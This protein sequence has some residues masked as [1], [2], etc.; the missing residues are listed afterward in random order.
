MS[1]QPETQIGLDNAAVPAVDQLPEYEPLTPDLVEDEAVRGDFVIRWSVVLLGLLFGWTQ[2]EDTSLLVRIRSGQLHPI[3][4]GSDVFSASATDRSWINLGWLSDVVLAGAYSVGGSRALTVLGALAA[5]LTFWWLSR[6]SVKGVSTW[7]GSICGMLALVAAFPQ[8]TPGPTG[9]TLLGTAAVVYQLFRWSEQNAGSF[10]WSIPITMFLWSQLDPRSWVG[11]VLIVLYTLS[12]VL[13]RGSEPNDPPN[14]TKNLWKIVGCS[15]LL[16]IV[17]PL[18]YHVVMSPWQA[19]ESEYPE[20]REYKVLDWPQAWQW[21]PVYSEEFQSLYD[22]FNQAA[23]ALCGICLLSM[24]LNFKRLTWEWLM[25]WLGIVALAACGAHQL[26]VAALVS[27]AIATLNCQ[28][29]YQSTFS[30]KY[31]VDSLPLAWNRGGRAITVIL[32]LLLGLVASNGMLMGRDGRRIGAGFSPQLATSIVGAE[33]LAKEVASKEVFNFRLEQGDLLIWAGMR[34]YVDRRVGLY[35]QGED[36]LLTKHRELRL[37]TLTPTP[38]N[39]K[40]GK[41]EVWKP[42]FERLKI[43]HAIPRLSGPSPDYTTLIEMLSQGWAL[44]SLQSFGAILSRVDSPDP[45]FQKYRQTHPDVSFIRQ[46]FRDPPTE[47]PTTIGPWLFPRRPTSYDKYLWQPQTSLNDPLQLASHEQALMQILSASPPQDEQT[48]ATVVSLAVS[49]IRHARQGLILDP[50][51]AQGYRVLALASKYLYRLD[52]S[53]A[54]QIGNPYPSTVWLYQTIHGLNHSLQLDPNNPIAHEELASLHLERGKQ[55][56]ALNHM[57]QLYRLTGSYTSLAKTDPR[58]EQMSKNN[59]KIVTELKRHLRRVT[60]AAMKAQADGSSWEKS[61]DE[62]LKGQCPGLALKYMEENRTKVAQ[63]ARFQMMQVNLL[64]DIGRT[65]D[66]L[67]QA[68]SLNR[69][70]PKTGAD[71]AQ[72]MSNEVRMLTAISSLAIGDNS[73]FKSQVELNTRFMLESSIRTLLDQTPL[74]TGASIQLDLFPASSGMAGFHSLFQA[75]ENQA[76]DELLIAQSEISEWKNES[77]QKRLQAVLDADPNVSLRPLLTLYL[78]ML[79]GQPLDPVSPEQRAA[80]ET[81]AAK[82]KAAQDQ[83]ASEEQK[84]KEPLSAE[85][86]PPA[87]ETPTE[88]KTEATPDSTPAPAIPSTESQPPTPPAESPREEI[89][90]KTP[91]ETTSPP[92]T[93][94]PSAPADTPSADSSKTE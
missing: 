34:P 26:P 74:T 18:H 2:I 58:Y 47:T 73:Q 60:E 11:V 43:N 9:V 32:L 67:Q 83:Q 5:A 28:M 93:E 22:V 70:I 44:T 19:Y 17:H 63:N 12:W 62:A 45:E 14:T 76:S 7:W 13:L 69:M 39:P 53:Y 79:S 31:T 84:A 15:L 33:K 30:Q 54:S 50:Q 81:E 46:A 66:A 16:W 57:T 24:M 59:L 71:A 64:L 25:P 85:Q 61:L 82:Q 92:A 89:G 6:T 90:S 21:Y 78:G 88:P 10:S 27:A 29:W 72:Q 35:S 20:L 23:L 38:K 91:V 87:S 86:Q 37:A 80:I 56:I 75:P 8:L 68:E 77:A 65:E 48:L 40:R 94:T 41:P 4:G 3:P 42:E 55:D 51:S 49:A 52:T 36:N 1:T